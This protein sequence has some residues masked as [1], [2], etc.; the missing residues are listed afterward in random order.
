[1]IHNKIHLVRPGCLRP[2]IVQNRGLL[3]HLSFVVILFKIYSPGYTIKMRWFKCRIHGIV[4]SQL[5]GMTY[6]FI[7][8]AYLTFCSCISSEADKTMLFVLLFCY[9]IFCHYLLIRFMTQEK[10]TCA[11]AWYFHLHNSIYFKF[12]INKSFLSFHTVDSSFKLSN[13]VAVIFKILI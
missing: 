11:H 4:H 1:M 13:E 7:A 8:R 2:N 10:G 9:S 12:I 3:K 6:I 5:R